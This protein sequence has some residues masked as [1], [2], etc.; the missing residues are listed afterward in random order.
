MS[1]KLE[2]A[3][4]ARCGPEHLWNVF[5]EIE[6]WPRWDPDAIKSVRWVSGAPWSKGARFEIKI[7]KPMAYTITPELLD[8]DPPVFLHWRGKGSG[9]T[10]EQFFIFK[11]VDEE[12]TEMRTLQ[13]FSGAPIALL[14]ARVRQPILDGIKHMFDRIRS[15]AEERFR[16]E[17]QP[18]AFP[19]LATA[20]ELCS[21]PTMAISLEHSVLAECKPEHVWK[22]FQDITLWPASVPRVIGDA[23]WTEG[24]PWQKGSKFKMKL[25]QPMPM[26]ARPEIVDCNPASDVHWIAAGSAVTA[27]QWFRFDSQEDGKTR[28]SA[29]QEFS[30]PMTFMFGETIQKQIAQMY[31][32]WLGVLKQQGEQTALAETAGA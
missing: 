6:Q 29:K 15:E 8:V 25:L 27:E 21:N 16:V 12:Q 30:G 3:T 20:G 18:P 24:E 11:P 14:G 13:E 28:V 10:G 4:I 31:E 17:K 9:I 1:L 19:E 26:Y 5:K 7:A 32:E 2:Y 23:S 22:H